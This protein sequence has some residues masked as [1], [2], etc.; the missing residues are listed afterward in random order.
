[1]KL[2]IHADCPPGNP[3]GIGRYMI[4]LV[5]AL[6]SGGHHLETWTRWRW[7]KQ[8]EKMLAGT[9]TR[10]LPLLSTGGFTDGI[11]PG[12]YSK[13]GSIHLVH[14]PNGKLLPSSSSF[15][16]TMMVHDLAFLLFP[17][18]K[19]PGEADA[20]KRKIEKAVTRADGILVNSASTRDDLLEWFPRARGKTHL[21][22]L[23]I[24]HLKL[25]GEV[26]SNQG[27]HI[28]TVGTVEPR[29]NITRLIM[30]YGEAAGNMDS[31]PPLV[32]AGGMGYRS[33][34]ILAAA[35]ASPVREKIRFTGYVT[36]EKLLD[37]Y[38]KAV[39]LVH[40]AIHEGFGFT[41]PEALGFGLPVVS[42]GNGALGELYSEAVYTVDP[43]DHLDIASGIVRALDQGLTPSLLDA[44]RGLFQKLTWRNC[45]DA[46]L[47]A[48]DEILK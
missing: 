4:E 15:R 16:Q 12:H 39:C 7:K 29:K 6:E 37:L 26:S 5:K 33:E 14:S 42:S 23:G 41:V 19:P 22:R 43:R 1:M 10:V 35:E 34:D 3:T 31:I 40:P 45:A 13:K 24:D 17:G 44:A 48:F 36:E 32:I 21:T 38:R 18:T 9:G 28:L 47:Q 25:P 27:E 11:L 46:T 30:A 20:W 2:A 8:V